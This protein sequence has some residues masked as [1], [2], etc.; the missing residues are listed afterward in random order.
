MSWK[1]RDWDD[2]V[3]SGAGVSFEGRLVDDELK[4]SDEELSYVP[5][6]TAEVS[7]PPLSLWPVSCVWIISPECVRTTEHTDSCW[8]VSRSPQRYCY[9]GPLAAV[10]IGVPSTHSWEPADCLHWEILHPW[11]DAQWRERKTEEDFRILP[12]RYRTTCAGQTLWGFWW[13]SRWD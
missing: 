13:A 8:R 12:E 5:A 1:P 7:V 9:L 4:R 6:V 11:K 3:F 10:K 2:W